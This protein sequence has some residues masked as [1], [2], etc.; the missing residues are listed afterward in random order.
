[1][2]LTMVFDLKGQLVQ[3][4]GSPGGSSII[5]FVAKT[6]IASVDWD[7]DPQAAADL[8]NVAN[9]NGATEM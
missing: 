2:A 1:M 9:R 3:V 4:V 7:L 8:L 6:V 5:P